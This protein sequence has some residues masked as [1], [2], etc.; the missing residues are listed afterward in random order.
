MVSSVPHRRITPGAFWRRA[1]AL[2]MCWIVGACGTGK[3]GGGTQ[4]SDITPTTESSPPDGTTLPGG[5]VDDPKPAPP[6]PVAKLPRIAVAV[7][8]SP[9]GDQSLH[10]GAVRVGAGADRTLSVSNTGSADLSV[11]SVSGGSGFAAP[12]S[13]TSDACSGKILVPAATCVV[14][15]RFEPTVVGSFNAGLTLASN[16]ASSPTFVVLLDGSGVVYL[17][18]VV[19]TD[20]V[21]ASDDLRLPFGFVT[22]GASRR[23]TV[24]VSNTGAGDLV[25]GNVASVQP[26]AAPFAIAADTCSNVTV[27]P[28]GRCTVSVAFSPTVAAPA[29]G[30]FDIP[31]TDPDRP[32]ISILLDATGT[33]VPQCFAAEVCANSIDDDCNRSTDEA[34]CI[35]A[36][37]Y[38]ADW[39]LTG[40]VVDFAVFGTYPLYLE[41]QAGR[42]MHVTSWGNDCVG[43]F[44][45]ATRAAIEESEYCL[46]GAAD[47][48]DWQM[49]VPDPADY[50]L[51]LARPPTAGVAFD[52]DRG[53]GYEA[54]PALDDAHGVMLLNHDVAPVREIFYLLKLPAGKVR[55]RI[56]SNGVRM[57][58]ATAVL[59]RLKEQDHYYHPGPAYPHLFFTQAQIDAIKAGP[60]SA[61]QQAILD[62]LTV[63]SASNEGVTDL[64]S[65]GRDR[66]GVLESLIYDGV[67]HDSAAHRAKAAELLN[68]FVGWLALQDGDYATGDILTYGYDMRRLG[69]VY[70]E[71]APFAAALL[72]PSDLTTLRERLSIEMMRHALSNLAGNW[73]RLPRQG[74]WTVS[75]GQGGLLGLTLIN[76]DKLARFYVDVSMLM[77][78]T[79]LG[80]NLT[81][82]GA[83]LQAL[84]DYYGWDLTNLISCLDAL[85]NNPGAAHDDLW[86][87][88]DSAMH[89]YLQWLVYSL[90]PTRRCMGPFGTENCR[91]VFYETYLQTLVL[92]ARHYQDGSLQWL[93]DTLAGPGHAAYVVTGTAPEGLAWYVGAPSAVDPA[94][95]LPL[96]KV[97]RGNEHIYMRTGWDVADFAFT[98]RCGLAGNHNQREQGSF[99]MY[100]DGHNYVQTY[101]G[102]DSTDPFYYSDGKNFVLIDGLGQTTFGMSDRYGTVTSFVHSGALDFATCDT[103]AAYQQPPP[104]RAAD[105][106]AQPVDYSQRR[107]VFVRPSADAAGYYVVF[108]RIKAVGSASHR[109]EFQLHTGCRIPEYGGGPTGTCTDPIGVQTPGAPVYYFAPPEAA[110][111]RLKVV[112]VEPDAAAQVSTVTASPV[113]GLPEELRIRGADSAVG[114]EF[115]A[116]LFP[117][118]LASR[119]MPALARLSP[120]TNQVGFTLGPDTVLWS[121][122]GS[123]LNASGILSDATVAVTRASGG[124]L[125]AV[126]LEGTYLSVD[127]VPHLALSAPCNAVLEVNAA[128]RTVTVGNDMTTGGTID[129]QVGGLTPAAGYACST[130]GVSCGGLTANGAGVVTIASVGPGTNTFVLTA[131]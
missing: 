20:S 64:A 65:L 14:A 54:L 34:G 72:S 92:A 41:T 98:S 2:G 86:S 130:A 123:A 75:H 7:S 101:N 1:A 66:S 10:F 8:G 39:K 25:L 99:I 57:E 58:L 67:F 115:V 50:V 129:V 127:G 97:T 100:A 26:L 22:L 117:E 31:S 128:D 93:H 62:G 33:A 70:D 79:S 45:P 124:L 60:R 121:K 108:D 24:T 83:Y 15:V 102:Y 52:V 42:D 107:F 55:F 119:T 74:G 30:S 68:G 53:S 90:S 28:G 80:D 95:V 126:L 23:E 37:T 12:F 96:G 63:S 47:Q 19:V 81:E 103:T 49:S 76:D 18:H 77:F 113:A 27:A 84:G 71:L 56:R 46:G 48:I 59:A 6:E 51:M 69:V 61:D 13:I 109:Y 29:S 35:D 110:S 88:Q 85:D 4:S 106:T 111:H 122:D 16:D 21:I 44:S 131:Q 78:K 104:S 116:V 89:K 94:T 105:P 38:L 40:E 5:A 9:A 43:Q 91:N 3:V 82:D 112:I 125:L 114:A 36:D 32:S 17:P 118:D 120:A 73:W 11:T 87:F